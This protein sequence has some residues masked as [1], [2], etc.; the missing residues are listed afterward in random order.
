MFLMARSGFTQPSDLLRVLVTSVMARLKGCMYN[1]LASEEDQKVLTTSWN[2]GYRT[3][4]ICVKQ[5]WN[6][7]PWNKQAKRVIVKKYK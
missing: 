4:G 5:T 3:Y 6:E 7:F 2:L 1:S